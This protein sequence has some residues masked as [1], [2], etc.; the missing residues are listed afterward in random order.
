MITLKTYE[1]KK[2]KL[3]DAMMDAI[4]DARVNRIAVKFKHNGKF[5][6]ISPRD[7]DRILQL[8]LDLTYT[9]EDLWGGSDK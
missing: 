6:Y 5:Y 3:L 4:I 2:T 1:I 9:K 8:A 7:A